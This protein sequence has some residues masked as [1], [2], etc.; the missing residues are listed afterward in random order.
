MDDSLSLA[1]PMTIDRDGLQG[2]LVVLDEMKRKTG[3]LENSADRFARTMS[4]AF[5]NGVAS[6]KQFDDV[7]KSVALRMS[8]LVLRQA[9][10]PV[11]KGI[12]DGLSSQIRSSS[13]AVR[14]RRLG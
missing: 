7:L 5:V 9:L 1:Q 10:T 13:A 2:C 4:R 6:G 8:D 14:P 3:D 12:G 11:T